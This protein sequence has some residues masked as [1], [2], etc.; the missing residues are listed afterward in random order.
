MLNSYYKAKSLFCTG[1][2][3]QR[4]ASTRVMLGCWT[5][6]INCQNALGGLTRILKKFKIQHFTFVPSFEFLFVSTLLK[7][8]HS[9]SWQMLKSDKGETRLIINHRRF[10]VA[11]TNYQRLYI[12]INI[13]FCSNNLVGFTWVMFRVFL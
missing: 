5:S 7:N 4:Q 12:V 2:N 6:S 11:P 3:E 8:S 10:L 13:I 9:C 1:V